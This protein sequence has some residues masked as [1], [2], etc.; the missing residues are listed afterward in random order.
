LVDVVPVLMVLSTILA[1]TTTVLLVLFIRKLPLKYTKEELEEIVDQRL[2]HQ[3]HVVK[4]FI[5]EQLAPHMKEFVMKYDAADAR[6][7]G[8]KPV[9]YIVY[10]G[11]SKAYDT[12]QPIDEIVFVEVKTSDKGERGPDKNEAKIKEAISGKR[13]RYDVVTIHTGLSS[14]EVKEMQGQRGRR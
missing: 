5:G 2:A 14:E 6:F 7:L 12:D 8:G 3:L 10:K 13:V 1:S 9:D 4:G 11:Y